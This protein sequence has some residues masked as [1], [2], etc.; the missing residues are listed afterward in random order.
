VAPYTVLAV[1]EYWMDDFTAPGQ[2][3]TVATDPKI[4]KLSDEFGQY[5]LVLQCSGCG[6][7]R[8]AQPHALARLC[9]WDTSIDH[10]VRRLRCSKCGKKQ[11]T[12]RAY[13][14][15]KPRGHS[16]LPR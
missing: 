3:L 16:S 15:T 9:G 4:N 10:V 2:E 13:L 7:E 1:G 11:C 6:H 12:W 14:P 5:T 8:H